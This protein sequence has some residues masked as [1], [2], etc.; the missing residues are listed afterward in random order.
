[1]TTTTAGAFD[2]APGSRERSR[3]QGFI[4]GP[5]YDVIFFIL[6]PLLA[7]AMTRS[8]PTRVLPRTPGRPR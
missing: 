8:P 5:A 6:A 1:M 3:N 2:I 7:L 4:A